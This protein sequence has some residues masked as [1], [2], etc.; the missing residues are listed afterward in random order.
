MSAKGQKRTLHY[1]TTSSVRR[2]KGGT[3][4]PSDL[5]VLMFDNELEL[6]W[7]N[8]RRVGRFF[9][10]ENTADLNPGFTIG[11]SLNLVRRS[12]VSTQQCKFARIG[13]G[14]PRCD[15]PQNRLHSIEFSPIAARELQCRWR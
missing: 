5:A 3:L 1:S 7:L 6:P 14:R 12:K 15:G 11:V 9:T 4:R 8:D 13:H 10:A 2:V